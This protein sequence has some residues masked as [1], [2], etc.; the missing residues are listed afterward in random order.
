MNRAVNGKRG[1][2]AGRCGRGVL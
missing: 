1:P 2:A